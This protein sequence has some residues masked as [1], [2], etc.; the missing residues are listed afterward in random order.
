MSNNDNVYDPWAV[1]EG[2]GSLPERV[3]F[4]EYRGV[5]DY[6]L[7]MKDGT[8]EN[9]W[10]WKTVIVSGEFKGRE[11]PTLTDA[12][13]GIANKPRKFVEGMI[14]RALKSGDKVPALLAEC[15]GKKFNA[16]Y[17]RHEKYPSSRPSIQS[18]TI[19]PEM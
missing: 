1:P 14:G 11:L 13:I 4:V 3:Y 12:K 19:P 9:R 7:A 10:Q 15:V 2:N 16:D 18:L 6:G 5:D 17:R 8:K